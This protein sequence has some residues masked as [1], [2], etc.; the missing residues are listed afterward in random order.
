MRQTP[1]LL[2]EMIILSETERGKAAHDNA[3]LRVDIL[4]I[5]EHDQCHTTHSLATQ[6]KAS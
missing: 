2:H 5:E 1:K 6:D 3:Q 4:Q